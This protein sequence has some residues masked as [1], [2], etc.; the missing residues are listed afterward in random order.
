[1][2][3]L[4]CERCE[5][6]SPLK[7]ASGSKDGD[8]PETSR[9]DIMAQHVRFV[10]RAGGKVVS[11]DASQA[12]EFE[13]SPLVTYGG[14]GLEAFVKGKTIQAPRLISSKQDF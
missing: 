8:S 4:E 13:I 6:F 10:E 9:A 14:E 1:M 11:S 2:A 7:N 12:P 3:V 5:E